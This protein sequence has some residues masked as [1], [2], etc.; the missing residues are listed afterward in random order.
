MQP[1]PARSVRYK[2]RILGFVVAGLALAF[3]AQAHFTSGPA[4]SGPSPLTAG[5]DAKA[6]PTAGPA[7]TVAALATLL[8]PAQSAGSAAKSGDD[9]VATASLTELAHAPATR[10]T[11]DPCRA[12]IPHAQAGCRANGTGFNRRDNGHGT[13]GQD[14]L[15]IRGRVMNPDGFGI[16]GVT[17][18]LSATRVYEEGRA[19][20]S[21]AAGFSPIATTDAYGA[22]EFAGLPQGDYE[23]RA[24]AYEAYGPARITA[25]SG[26][27]KADI[28]LVA[29]QTRIVEGEVIGAD[30]E[31]LEGVIV[32][33]VLVGVPGTR[34]DAHGAY[35]LPLTF[36]PGIDAVTIRFQLAGFLEHQAS[37]VLPGVGS[38]DLSLDVD[39]QPVGYWTNVSGV[40]TD[41]D[42]EPL[43][44]KAVR[45]RQVGGRRSYQATTDGEGR[46]AFDAVEAPVA[47][48]LSVSG[49]PDHRD[50]RQRI[51]VTPDAAEIHVVVEPFEF[52]AVSGRLVNADGEPIPNFSLVLRHAAS[53][54]SG[55]VVSSD[56]DGDFH[57]PKAPAGELVVSSQS[58]PAVVVNGLRLEAGG[59]LDLPLVLDWGVHELRGTVVDEHRRPVPAAQVVLSWSHTREGVTT[60]TTRRAATDAQ[61]IF[62][63]ADLGPGPHSIRVDRPGHRPVRLAHD[64]SRQGYSVTVNLK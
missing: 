26:A 16:P 32:S 10:G 34:T 35:R 14:G 59:E 17:V 19:G 64:V 6:A 31:P 42:G 50:Y 63:F 44:G 60:M 43:A 56:A 48:V 13:A 1:K 7:N 5:S 54:T 25:R 55:A 46:Y 52:G 29:R 12:R 53:S 38:E 45:L 49:A 21:L 4:P 18:T 28:V 30:G 57:V 23:V 8:S 62:E 51:E 33:P 15:P 40:V 24:A 27:A 20:E 37:V 2:K 11:Y 41:D 9:P 39:L 58:S 47:Y 36:K 22:Y 3:A 61:G